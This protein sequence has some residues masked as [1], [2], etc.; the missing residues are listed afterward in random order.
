[1]IQK[2]LQTGKMRWRRVREWVRVTGAGAGGT[3]VI[4]RDEIN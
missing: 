4:M 3:E 1:M 2:D